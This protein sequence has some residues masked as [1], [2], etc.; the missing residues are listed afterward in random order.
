MT[1]PVISLK[2]SYNSVVRGCPGIPDTLPRVEC[3]FRVRSNDGRPFKIDK[4]EVSLKC[5]ESLNNQSHHSFSSKPKVEKTT[6]LYRKVIKMTERKMLGIDIPFTIGLPDDIKETNFNSSFGRTVTVLE[7]FA[8]YNGQEDPQS[9]SRVINVEKY[10]F[11]PNSKLFPSVKRRVI[12]QDKK[13]VVDYTVRNPCVTTDDTLHVDFELKPNAKLISEGSA[14]AST[15]S[16]FN[17]KMKSRLKHAVVSL[18]E[19]LEVYDDGSGI[20]TGSGGIGNDTRENLLCETVHPINEL[21]TQ[22]GIKW[23]M[24]IK[25]FTKSKFFDEFE[26]TLQ[27]PPSLQRYAHCNERSQQT[28]N[29]TIRTELLQ[30]K[31]GYGHEIPFQYHTSITT[32]R[33]NLYRVLHGITVK[34]KI[35]NGKSFQM[36]QPIDITPWESIH[37][38]TIEQLILQERETARYANQFYQSYG[39]LKRVP[40]STTLNNIKGHRIEYP[41][42]P[43]VVY[44]NDHETLKS[45]NILYNS[46]TFSRI[47]LIE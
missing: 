18:K 20:N 47:P 29:P 34:F 12:S 41:P 22:N 14:I 23:S 38:K 43:P 21:I 42:L 17:K 26:R 37:L 46:S 24:D 11:L 16:I 5:I 31:V 13:Y 9:F 35:N 32:T 30:N 45:L 28:N 4:I 7:C 10:T 3:E 44:L 33:G 8:Y 1:F 19:Y 2:P 25:V 6:V 36:S 39:G 40:A 27:E 15:P